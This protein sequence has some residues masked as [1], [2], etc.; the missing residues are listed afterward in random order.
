MVSFNCSPKT[1]RSLQTFIYV[2]LTK[3]VELIHFSDPFIRPTYAFVR[4]QVVRSCFHSLDYYS[5]KHTFICRYM[6]SCAF[7]FCFFTF[8]SNFHHPNIRNSVDFSLIICSTFLFI[9]SFYSYFF[10]QFVSS[11]VMLLLLLLVLALLLLDR[12]SFSLP[13]FDW[14]YGKCWCI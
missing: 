5:H 3:L 8:F 14:L 12:R 6:C 10:S 11:P 9:S 1:W 4:M 7:T 13:L 2:S